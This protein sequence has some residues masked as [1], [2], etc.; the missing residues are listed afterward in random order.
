MRRFKHDDF[1][2]YKDELLSEIENT[3][4]GILG[5]IRRYDPSRNDS[6]AA[7][8][9]LNLPRRM[10]E[11]NKKIFPKSFTKQIDEQRTSTIE[12]AD[13]TIE[14]AVDESIT[15]TTQE[16]LNL[17]KKIKLPD[18]QVEKV[19]EAVRKTF[20]TKLPPP[21]SPQFKKALRKAFDTELFKEL[22]TNV[23]NLSI[24]QFD[25]VSGM[26]NFF[27]TSYG[28]PTSE[29]AIFG[30]GEITVRLEKSTRLPDKEPLNLPSL[31][32]SL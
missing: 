17:R 9:S 3:D 28:I 15:P 22:K 20:G 7:F 25:T 11:V 13:T 24:F 10:I 32:F 23:F 5:L 2:V 18:G 21:D 14:E 4:R 6:L 19:R 16:K 29:I 26:V 31:P 30:S 12:E 27:A 8:I 1:N